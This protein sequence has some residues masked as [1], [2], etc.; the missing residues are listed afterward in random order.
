[1]SYCC[2]TESPCSGYDCGNGTCLIN[3]EGFA[4]C[5]CPPG[6]YGTSCESKSLFFLDT[7]GIFNIFI[8]DGILNLNLNLNFGI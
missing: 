4:Q 1:M 8:N 7:L 6:L 3:N 2:I 5:G